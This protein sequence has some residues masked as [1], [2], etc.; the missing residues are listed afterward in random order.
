VGRGVYSGNTIGAI[1]P[2]PL[3]G[4]L[5]EMRFPWSEVARKGA[6]QGS[7]HTSSEVLAHSRG[8]RYGSVFT[9]VAAV[10]CSIASGIRHGSRCDRTID[11]IANLVC[12]VALDASICAARRVPG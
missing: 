2:R 7:L 5:A 11:M 6:W 4:V 12:A 3:G 8:E 10:M 9:L 1:T